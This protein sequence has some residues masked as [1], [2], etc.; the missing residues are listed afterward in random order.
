MCAACEGCRRLMCVGVVLAQGIWC[1][2]HHP[3]SG[4]PRARAL[5]N[6]HALFLVDTAY[7]FWC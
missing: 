7:V 4:V 2:H 3:V 6:N 5:L 1:R